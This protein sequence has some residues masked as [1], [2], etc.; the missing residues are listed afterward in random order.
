M[1][2]LA[3]T[4]RGFEAIAWV[5]SGVAGLLALA[6]WESRRFGAPLRLRLERALSI[7][8]V[9]AAQKAFN[10]A[11][12]SGLAG[13][14][15]G[16]NDSPRAKL[17]HVMHALMVHDHIRFY[18][19]RPPATRAVLIPK[20]EVQ[21]SMGVEAG[22]NDLTDEMTGRDVLVKDTSLN[23]TDFWFYLRRLRKGEAY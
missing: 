13:F 22:S 8:F 18:G 16:M 10:T 6:L 15:F 2:Q 1:L 21:Q 11:A 14:A 12:A 4:P 5:I 19:C 9:D 3:M 23:R 20:E 17:R 7:K